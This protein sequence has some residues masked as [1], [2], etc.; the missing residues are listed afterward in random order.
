MDLAR[1]AAQAEMDLSVVSMMPLG[2]HRYAGMLRA[3]GVDVRSLDLA[4]WW[5][6]RGPRR[7]TGLIDRLAPDVLHSHLKHADVVAGRVAGKIGV[8]HVSTLHVIEDRVGGLAARKRDWAAHRRMRSAALT[9]AV[10]D[11]LRSWYLAT[12]P[13]RPERVVTLRNGV[14]DPGRFEP[15]ECA[16]IRA[17]IGVP[18][19][20]VV[21]TT[22][23]VLRPGKGHDVLMEAAAAVDGVVF[24]IVGD[25]PNMPDIR[26]RAAALPAERIVFTG[27]RD[28]VPRL[29]AASDLVVHPA[30][31]DALPT[32]LIQ[33][34]AAGIPTV[35][36]D[37]GGIPEIV[38]P[39]AGVLVPP[40]DPVSLAA[41]IGS[42]AD[43]GDSRRW[44]GKAARERFDQE[45]DGGAWARRLVAMYR[46]LTT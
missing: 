1:V 18:E 2:D 28:D 6:P 15:A 37:V 30:L 32:A 45:F 7:L 27:F 44:M 43:D 11:A 4:G 5:D 10:S 16:E 34:L 8:P 13:E 46:T 21:A 33:A 42:L 25:G 24:V 23:A 31:F 38:V 40:G 12:F 22:V 20:A 17:E 19:D 26:R 41:A 29:L 9:I 39:G 14:P 35:A 3:A 36:S